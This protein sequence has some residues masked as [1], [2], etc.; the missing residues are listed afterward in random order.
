MNASPNTNERLKNAV[1]STAVP[2]ALEASIR[3]SLRE[4]AIQSDNGA[5]LR[6]A[7]KSMRTP[8]FLDARIRN[9]IH[10]EASGKRWAPRLA[11]VAAGL[12]LAAG[13]AI[14]Y[15]LGHLR[16]TVGSQESYIASVTTRVATL[17]RVGLADHIHCSVFR[18]YPKNTPTTQE[19]IEKIDAR[20]APLVPI[21][22]SQV[23]DTYRMTLAHECK[24]HGRRFVHLSLR[25]DSNMMSLVIA[26]KGDGESFLTENML[27]A[28]VQAG[29]P[30]YQSNVQRFE[31]TAFETDSHLV[32]FVSDL[33]KKQNTDMMLALSPR[34]KDF[35]VKLEL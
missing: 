4:E 27:P 31:L 11:P 6:E 8:P 7:V 9:R 16:L 30:M 26:R 28:L 21:V 35:F 34:L 3:R 15:Q 2:P 5:R 24:Y 33:P 10:R 12:V 13:L 1:K 32:Y 22:R 23:P 20:F 25:N 19:L 17:M 14:A 29:I 18:K